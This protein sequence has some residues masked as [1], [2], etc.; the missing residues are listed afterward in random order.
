MTDR[1]TFATAALTGLLADDGDRIDH[2]M[3]DFT[4]RAYE[5]ADVMLRERE[6]WPAHRLGRTRPGA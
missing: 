4:T 6:T 3:I 5:W 1:D 2:A